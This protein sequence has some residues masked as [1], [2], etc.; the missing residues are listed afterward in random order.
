MN[1]DLFIK[2]KKV[3][4]TNKTQAQL[5]HLLQLA[6]DE[7]DR[8]QRIVQNYPPDRMEQYGRPHIQKLQRV[9]DVI[10]QHIST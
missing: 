2:N 1:E 4:L 6:K 3:V 7:V 5:E 9:V 10:S 8:Y